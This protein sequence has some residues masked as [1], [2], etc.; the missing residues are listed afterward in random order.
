[1]SSIRLHP[2]FGV[3]PTVVVCFW[4]GQD[5]NELALLG[6]AF[7][8][9]APRRMVVD[10]APCESCADKMATGITIIEARDTDPPRYT[11][12]WAVVPEQLVG[13]LFVEGK[14]TDAI[15]KHRKAL[16]EPE[17][18]EHLFADVITESGEGKPS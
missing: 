12:R 13:K 8:D 15:L 10:Y 16:M 5:K 1:M 2:K 11:G 7:K 18:F 3:N 9:E 14:V 17:A 4:C 6:A